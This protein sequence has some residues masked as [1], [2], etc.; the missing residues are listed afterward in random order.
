MTRKSKIAR[1]RREGWT[2]LEGAYHGTSDDRVGRW[3]AHKRGQPISKLGQGR[4]TKTEVWDAV[5]RHIEALE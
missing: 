1:L 5:I 3:Y 4:A 2:V